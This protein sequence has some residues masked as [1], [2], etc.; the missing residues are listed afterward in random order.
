M[1]GLKFLK[2]WGLKIIIVIFFFVFNRL[3]GLIGAIALLVIIGVYTI[4]QKLHKEKKYTKW[5]FWS[6]CLMLMRGA[7]MLYFIQIANGVIGFAG[8]YEVAVLIMATIGVILLALR[9]HT[10]GAYTVGIGLL[11]IY[12]L[13]LLG[14][15]LSSAVNVGAIVADILFILVGGMVLVRNKFD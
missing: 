1:D 9:N 2:D 14:V 11:D 4:G 8:A 15:D 6:I 3:F 5:E 12:I 13:L 10:G 7:M